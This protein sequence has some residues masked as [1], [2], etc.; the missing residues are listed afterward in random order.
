MTRAQVHTQP[1]CEHYGSQ[2]A[3]PPELAARLRRFAFDYGDT[4]AAYLVTEGDR[5]YF[6]SSGRRGVVGFCRRGRYVTIADGLFAAPEDRAA[7]LGEFL[8]FAQLNRWHTSYLNVPRSDVNLFRSQGCEVTKCGEEPRVRLQHVRWQGKTWEW[9]RRQESYC[10]RHGV[11]M[12][13]VIPE[14]EGEGYAGR[15]VPQ[16]EQISRDHIS[17]TLHR[18]ELRFFVSQFSAADLRQRRLFIAEQ[19]GAIIAFIVCNPGLQGNFWAV[20]VYRRRRDAT[21]GVIPALI[22]HAMRQMKSEDVDY[23]SLSL[24]PFLRCT[25]LV[26]DSVIFRTVA[27]TWWRFLNPIYDV[28]GLFHFKSRFR[29]DYREMYLAAYPRITVRSLLAMAKTWQLFRFNPLRMA[30]R[31]LRRSPSGEGR[32]LATPDRASDRLIR[33]LR[34]RPP[35]RPASEPLAL[36]AVGAMPG[37]D[38]PG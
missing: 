26:G 5:E 36:A 9:V 35:A 6:W 23:F 21:R 13:E 18:R 2:L 31:S 32:G 25:P 37:G 17:G 1:G 10:K 24:A 16:L 4:Y 7:L 20:E 3:M 11:E 34:A 12:R 30:W 15:I 29:P 28:Q 38:E 8:A 19:Q 22:M 27:N 14:A 33:H